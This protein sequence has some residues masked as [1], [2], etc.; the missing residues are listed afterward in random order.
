MMQRADFEQWKS[1]DVAR[2]LALVETERRYFQD[3]FAALPVPLA[4]LDVNLNLLAVNRE[5]R[6]RFGLP[7]V[8]LNRSRVN[9]VFQAEG[10]T[11]GES[12]TLDALHPPTGKTFRLTLIRM[13]SWQ[14]AAEEEMLLTVEE[15]AAAAAPARTDLPWETWEYQPASESFSAPRGPLTAW[16]E[17]RVHPLDR[18]AFVAFYRQRKTQSI[19]YRTQTMDG[20]VK[21]MRDVLAPEVDGKRAGLTVEVTA[22]RREADHRAESAKREGLERLSGRLAHV[23]NNLLMII[24]GYAEDLREG[25]PVGDERVSNIDE[26]IKASERLAK[27][28]LQLNAVAHP[29]TVET[30][31]VDLSEW[32]LHLVPKLREVVWP[33]CPVDLLSA[34]LVKGVANAELLDQVFLE[35]ARL[36]RPCLSA[37]SRLELHVSAAGPHA[38]VALQ[39]VGSQP[40]AEVWATLLEPFAGPKQSGVDPPLGIAALVRPLE[41]AG[42]TIRRHGEPGEPAEILVRLPRSGAAEEEPEAG[43]ST[44]VPPPAPPPAV[45]VVEDEPGIRA[46]VR[47]ALK[48][49]GY[50]VIEAGEPAEAVRLAAARTAPID[51]LVTDLTMPGG[52][53]Q[54]L[55]ADL[56]AARPSLKVL[57]ISGYSED[58]SLESQVAAGTLPA[59]TAFL[60]KPFALGRFIEQ[61]REML[62]ATSGATD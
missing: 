42:G 8:E 17:A 22:D 36:L 39:L 47:K 28:T 7:G 54:Q 20:A 14:D 18:E 56:R 44:P 58:A 62:A 33:L 46:L 45:L 13:R 35:A 15:P 48:R 3:I 52:T 51:L 60:R 1:S 4:I 19:E 30:T 38:E 40:D 10:L 9:D 59:G 49:N 6:K 57:Y 2:L 41:H 34:P 43:T 26:I 16:S 53:G 31:E 37:T 11:P 25:L 23:A 24:G 32:G 61:V 50:D 27:L 29:G 21:W 12:A 55:A 5:F